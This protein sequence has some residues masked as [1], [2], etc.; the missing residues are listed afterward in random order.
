MSKTIEQ[1]EQELAEARAAA[2]Q[3]QPEESDTP[4]IPLDSTPAPETPKTVLTVG[5]F[6]EGTIL[7]ALGAYLGS[8]PFSEVV[9]LV[10]SLSS[11][12]VIRYPL[13]IKNEP[14]P[15]RS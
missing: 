15:A 11:T 8:R 14:Q 9:G 13:P 4:V 1:I 2:N 12:P 7:D 6:V 10:N 3:P 5:R